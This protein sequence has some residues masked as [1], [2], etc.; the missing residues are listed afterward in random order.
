MTRGLAPLPEALPD[1]LVRLQSVLPG[2]LVDPNTPFPVTSS[3]TSL[4]EAI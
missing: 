2:G 1:A 3:I 4:T